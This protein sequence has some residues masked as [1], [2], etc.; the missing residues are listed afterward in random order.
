MHFF[1]VDNIIFSLIKTKGAKSIV[2]KFLSLK[3]E[4]LSTSST[5]SSPPQILLWGTIVCSLLQCC[6]VPSLERGT[7]DMR[8]P[9]G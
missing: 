2:Y 5:L 4:Q 9:P 7:G 1:K 8:L 6:P 3:M